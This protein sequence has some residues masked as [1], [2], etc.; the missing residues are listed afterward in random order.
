VNA[1]NAVS[2]S[3]VRRFDQIHS[4]LKDVVLL[5][6]F[7]SNHGEIARHFVDTVEFPA[8]AGSGR[9]GQLVEV[10]DK[11]IA[12]SFRRLSSGRWVRR[13]V[14]FSGDARWAWSA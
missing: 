4:G 14:V 1:E 13:R 12:D 8:A 10:N 9:Y 2:L 3:E 6:R 11:C 5:L 7:A